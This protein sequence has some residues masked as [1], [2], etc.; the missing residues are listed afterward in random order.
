[1][2]KELLGDTLLYWVAVIFI[3]VWFFGLFQDEWRLFALSILTI[4]L[5]SIPKVIKKIQETVPDIKKFWVKYWIALFVIFIIWSLT[6]GVT[7]EETDILNHPTSQN[8]EVKP[9]KEGP[10]VQNEKEKPAI[11]EENTVEI[12][13]TNSPEVQKEEEI[14]KDQEDIINKK[15]EEAKEEAIKLQKEKVEQERIQKEKEEALLL[16]QEQAKKDEQAKVEKE[17]TT[18][19][20]N[21]KAK[22]GTDFWMIKYC[23][24]EQIKSRDKFYKWNTKNIDSTIFNTIREECVKKWGYD[25]WMRIYCEWNQVD[26]YIELQNM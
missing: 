10:L 17:I 7:E 6:L 24:N 5:L 16:K 19:K 20:D 4:W 18:I 3:F 25:F 2:K 13:K 22:W 1:M 8:E 23:I 14:Q 11:I 21:C 9:L 26:S 12:E 15:E